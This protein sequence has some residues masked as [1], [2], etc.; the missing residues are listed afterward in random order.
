MRYALKF[1]YDG[2][3]FDGYARQP[4]MN[5]VEDAII[6]AMIAQGILPKDGKGNFQSSSRTDK[7]VSAAGN[8]IAVTTSFRRDAILKALNV[9]LSGIV[10]HGIAQV[11]EDFNPR[12]AKKRSYRYILL[13]GQ[14]PNV[15]KMQDAA[16]I[17]LGEHDF[18]HFAKKDTRG[19]N[20]ILSIDKIQIRQSGEFV[21]IDISAHR[22]LWQLVRRLVAFILAMAN[23]EIELG[24]VEEMLS[25][26][27]IKLASPRTMPPE[28]LVLLDVDCG[29]V[30]EKL[31][32]ASMD[33]DERMKKAM[34]QSEI[35][36]NISEF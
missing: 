16:N 12:H 6:D 31:G 14:C 22:F 30:F 10:F 13:Q 32:G 4:D 2:Q 19:E 36:R 17:F 11:P 21:Y 18:T 34:I 23:N 24:K 35:M 5:T 28:N 26:S 7:G 25:G 15:R 9:K 1:A 33:F 20:P 3:A 27:S 29:I 8:I